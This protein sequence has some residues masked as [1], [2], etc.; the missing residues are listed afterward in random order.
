MT[1]LWPI[2]GAVAAVVVPIAVA[3]AGFL[4]H[5]SRRTAKNTAMLNILVEYHGISSPD[6]RPDGGD[7]VDVRTDGGKDRPLKGSDT[8]GFRAWLGDLQYQEVHLFVLGFYSGFVAVRPKRRAVPKGPGLGSGDWY[9]RA[10]YVL[11]YMAKVV[12]VAALVATRG[13]TGSVSLPF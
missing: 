12:A 13:G 5:L 10:G 9:H 1:D 4:L 8:V 6:A 3:L 11:G 7:E 2:V